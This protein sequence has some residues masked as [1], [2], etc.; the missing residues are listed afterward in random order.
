[1]IN[2]EKEKNIYKMK[3]S[4]QINPLFR[5]RCCSIIFL[6]KMSR[7]LLNVYSKCDIVKEM[8]H[9]YERKRV[10]EIMLCKYRVSKK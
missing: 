3:L 7:N 5:N 9:S 8:T 6:G 2:E 1:M 10:V 4:S